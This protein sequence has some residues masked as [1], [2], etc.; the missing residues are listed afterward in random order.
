MRAFYILNYVIYRWYRTRD[1]DPL[2]FSF[3]A[4][5]FLIS[6]N[7]FCFIY[8][9]E[10]ALNINLHQDKYYHYIPLVVF[11]AF[12]YLVLYRNHKYREVFA[13]L[14][15]KTN[16]KSKYKKCVL[17]YIITTVILLLATLINADISVD[18]HL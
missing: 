16:K 1:K 11:S 9:I 12:S 6:T 13:Y 3:I 5:V 10:A 17:V 7:I 2:I 18:G 8:L 4:P 14:D 15:K